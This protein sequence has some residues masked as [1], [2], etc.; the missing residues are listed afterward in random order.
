[1]ERK[2]GM[3]ETARQPPQHLTKPDRGEPPPSLQSAGE[4]N[5]EAFARRT[6]PDSSVAGSDYYVGS[7][8]AALD[9]PPP[10]RLMKMDRKGGE[11]C[12]HRCRPPEARKREYF[13]HF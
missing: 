10:P 6:E 7:R 5:G 4:K 12:R 8:L 1:M 9:S 13:F 2:T 11:T 3:D